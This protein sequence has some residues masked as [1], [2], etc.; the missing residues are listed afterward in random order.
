MRALKLIVISSTRA[1]SFAD[2]NYMYLFNRSPVAAGDDCT[3]EAAMMRLVTFAVAPPAQ[4][5][6]VL[7]REERP[8]QSEEQQASRY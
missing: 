8:T 2:N 5:S 1:T 7:G 4:V 3:K 6:M